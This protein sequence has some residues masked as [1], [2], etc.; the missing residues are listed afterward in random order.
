MESRGGLETNSRPGPLAL[1]HQSPWTLRAS[2][3]DLHL[4]ERSPRLL[5]SQKVGD[6]GICTS[7]CGGGHAVS[8]HALVFSEFPVL[9]GLWSSP[10]PGG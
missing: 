8:V 6:N 10:A 7:Y 5:G 3:L 9:S 4:P 2:D 1:L